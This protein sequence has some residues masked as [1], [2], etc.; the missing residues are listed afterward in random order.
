MKKFMKKISFKKDIPLIPGYLLMAF[1]VVF[2]VIA[3]GWIIFASLSTT[4]EVFNNK[5]L[6]SG[7]HFENYAKAILN[8]NVGAYFINSII[9]SV[10]SCFGVILISAPAAYVLA[11]KVFRGQKAILSAFVAALGIPQ[12]MIIMPLF[13]TASAL[14]LTGTK[15]A[16]GFVIFLYICLNMPF[17]VFFLSAFF[18]TVPSSLEEASM[19]DGCTP[20]MAFWKVMLPIAQPGLITV[21]IFNFMSVWNEYF[22][23]L[24]FANTPSTRTVSLGL[25][26][27]VQSMRYSGDWAGMFA[28]VVIVF[29]PSVVLY[30]FLSDKIIAGIT[31]GAVKG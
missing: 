15:E 8:H 11:F 25:Q 17:T 18:S 10:I 19:I 5:L 6:S 27:M 1:W 26:A 16:M 9:Y 31:G 21:T 7:L 14:Q 2:V 3:F 24:I 28:A 12:I 13:Y 23:A 20:A 22:I 29:V 30:L 4:K